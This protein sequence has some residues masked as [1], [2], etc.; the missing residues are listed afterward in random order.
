LD[1]SAALLAVKLIGTPAIVGGATLAGRRWGPTVAGWIGGLPLASGPLTYFLAIEQSPRFAAQSATATLAGLLGVSVFAVAFCRLAPRGPWMLCL[2]V[3]LAL[4]LAVAAIF[5]LVPVAA[6]VA[7][8]VDVVALTI[9]L[10]LVG[11][12]G[13]AEVI[14]RAPRWDLPARAAGATA[15]VVG[16]SA[17]ASA[18]GSRVVGLF[19]PFPVYASIM[20]SFTHAL[21]G[22]GAAA[23][24]I[25]GVLAGLYGFACFYLSVALL[26]TSN[27]GLAFAVGTVSALSVNAV[28]MWAIR[29]FG[30]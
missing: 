12:P 9:A 28:A 11:T 15:L 14:T 18:L 29:R 8:A 1:G 17:L 16:L 27:L 2:V 26:A 5:V 21:Y 25:R 7:F 4:Y 19:A 22:P 20:G 30:W 13:K 23:R 10:F 6:P 3:S 24:L